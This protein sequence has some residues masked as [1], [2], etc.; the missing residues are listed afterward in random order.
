[1]QADGGLFQEVVAVT[2]VYKDRV[3]QDCTAPS[4]SAAFDFDV[5]GS[6][7]TGYQSWQAALADGETAI[8]SASDSSG[9]WEVGVGTWN[10]AGNYLTR[11]TIL[12]SSNAGS[13]ETFSG[14]V[15]VGLSD[16]ASLH[17]SMTNAAEGLTPG[18]RLTLTTAV[19]V[20]TSDVTAATTVYYT[21][22]VHNKITLWNGDFWEAVEFSEVSLALGAVTSGKPYDVFAYMSSGALST[23][24]LV[25]TSDTARATA[26]TLQDGRYCKS[27]DKTRLYIGT[28]YTTSTTETEDSITN[29]YLYNFYNRAGK[30]LIGEDS[31]EHTYTTGTGR[32]WNNGTAS[33]AY[34]IDGHVSPPSILMGFS[35]RMARSTAST[36]GY[37]RPGMN[38]TELGGQW[39]A[40]GNDKDMRGGYAAIGVPVAGKNYVNVIEL[41]LTGVD[42]KNC[43]VVATI[44]C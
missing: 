40:S 6:T 33:H 37:L 38:G 3:E 14:A 44:L 30:K 23:E 13:S 26:I 2:L 32:V 34:F 10:E 18:G 39:Y 43:E 12:A 19:P 24:S 41:G 42:Y 35:A 25:W 15:T 36:C 17:G 16:S 27:G 20:T 31:T 7:P 1:M 11:T 29:R 5:G 8:Y 28:F 21:P 22:Y 9:N 4:A